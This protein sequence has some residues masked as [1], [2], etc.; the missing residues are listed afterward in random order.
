MLSNS[1][2]VY[3][4]LMCGKSPLKAASANYWSDSIKLSHRFLT[5]L[6]LWM[7]AA[8][9]SSFLC[10][11]LVKSVNLTLWFPKRR[12]DG[13][14]WAKYNMEFAG[15]VVNKAKAD[16][17]KDKENN[18]TLSAS[19]LAA[20]PNCRRNLLTCSIIETSSCPENLV[21]SGIFYLCGRGIWS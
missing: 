13:T 11:K 9:D 7:K 8:T 16:P 15:R 3:F 12:T 21:K 1:C 14:A 20:S 10:L 6:N 17:D 2:D 19:W 5:S 4:S 18:Q